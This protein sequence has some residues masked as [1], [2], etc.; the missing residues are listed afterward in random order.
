MGKGF[1]A[2]DAIE[3]GFPFLSNSLQKGGEIMY[4]I[5]KRT[6]E[7]IT[8]SAGLPDVEWKSKIYG[9]YFTKAE[10]T[11]VLDGLKISK[12]DVSIEYQQS[13]EESVNTDYLD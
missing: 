9:E 10:A 6:P 7:V 13:F 12:F 2:D 8:N 4:L 1:V 3:D 5:V 11:K